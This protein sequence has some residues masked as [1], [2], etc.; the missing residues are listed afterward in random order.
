MTKLTIR[1]VAEHAGVGVGTVSR[2]LN[3]S[4]H[5]SAATRRRVLSTIDA[6]GFKPNAVAR[7]LPRKTRF[8]NIGVITRPFINYY[9]F[10]ERLRGVQRAL[11]A[12]DE[13]FELLLFNTHT[14]R[15]YDERLMSIIQTGV[16]DGLL[17]I[18]LN[19]SEDQ[20]TVLQQ[21]G[22][23][24]VGLN[25]LRESNWICISTDNEIGGWRAT[26]YLLELGHRRIAYVGDEL[27]DPNGFITSQERY[28]GY[29]RALAEYNIAVD[30][31]LVRCGEHGYDTAK[32][33]MRTLLNLPTPPDAVFAMSDT[34]AL[35]CIATI[36]E[37]GLDVPGDISVIG[38][39]DLEI[40]YHTGLSTV[41]QH[42]ELSGQIGV[43][44][45]MHLIDT[46]EADPVPELPDVDVI[47]RQTTAPA[48]SS[49]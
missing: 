34:Q 28:A 8:R 23:P 27:S 3:N 4:P 46:R 12:S 9:S 44:Y 21:T 29:K 39:D 30:E 31:A 40:S 5:V 37:A 25:H 14:T 35:G 32:E 47:A 2:V 48:K 33:L 20:V 22:I 42:L 16:I 38:Y 49:R 19:L 17:I 11:Q 10:A 41:R 18:D 15:D 43:E 6:L 7:Q 24:F 45:L 26:S 1:D 13:P 36:R